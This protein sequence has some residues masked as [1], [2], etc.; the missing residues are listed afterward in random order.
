MATGGIAA[1]GGRMSDGCR[2]PRGSATR[3]RL[4]T[5]LSTINKQLIMA[6]YVDGYVLPVPK[7]SIAA[8]ARLAKK[9]SKIWKEHG[10]LDY[11]ECVGDDLDVKMGMPFPGA[12]TNRH[13]ELLSRLQPFSNLGVL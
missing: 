2:G 1:C 6:H 4:I 3:A 11:R 9:A 8:Y 13:V 10:A 12:V 7:K 5:Q